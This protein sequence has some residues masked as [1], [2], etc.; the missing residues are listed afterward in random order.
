MISV[1]IGRIYGVPLKTLTDAQGLIT[2]SAQAVNRGAYTPG[3]EYNTLIKQS[4][5]GTH[6]FVRVSISP[7]YK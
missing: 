6:K 4:D 3:I 5:L 7:R 1:L 2:I